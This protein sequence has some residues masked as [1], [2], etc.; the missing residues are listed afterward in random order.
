MEDT[1]RSLGVDQLAVAN[2]RRLD[3][4]PGLK[5]EGDQVVDLDD[6]LAVSCGF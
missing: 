5:A 6:Q 4:G 1:L 2:L 3:V